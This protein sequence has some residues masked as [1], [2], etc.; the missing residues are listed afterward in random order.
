M[1]GLKDIHI[2]VI[3]SVFSNYSSVNEAIIYGS[4]AKG[5][6]STGSDLKK[7]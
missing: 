4:R 1:F 3:Q 5:N 6:Y 2:K 7:H